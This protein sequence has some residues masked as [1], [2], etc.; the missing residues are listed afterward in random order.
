MKMKQKKELTDFLKN[1]GA[2]KSAGVIAAFEAVDRR[3]FV[4]EEMKNAAYFDEP[5]PIG[6][7]QTISQPSTVAFMLEH[8]GAQEGDI[9]FD[10]GSGSGWQATLLAH[11]AGAAGKVYTAEILPELCEFSGENIKKYPAL[12]GRIVSECGDASLGVADLAQQESI[13]K[14]IAA[15]SLDEVPA[16]WRAQLKVGGKMIYPGRDSLIEET[17]INGNEFKKIEYPGFVFVPFVKG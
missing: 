8:L 9:I 16:A 17:K 14:I 12:A 4:P 13:D 1:E 11:L 7:G 2:L 5:L 15:A 3:D 10:V 6:F